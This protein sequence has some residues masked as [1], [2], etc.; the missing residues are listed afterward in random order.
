MPINYY[1][2]NAPFHGGQQ[3]VLSRQAGDRLIKNDLLQLVLTSKGE[4]MMR[5]EWG[6]ILKT[7]VFGQSDD[8]IAQQIINDI[9]DAILQYETRISATVTVKRDDDAH[10]MNVV[11]SGNY[12]DQP[13]NSFLVELQVPLE[14][15]PER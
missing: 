1:G 8:I 3:N 14:Q 10:I 13:N 2:Y 15:L 9:T 7:S 5:P 6:T 12:I 11:I 4:R